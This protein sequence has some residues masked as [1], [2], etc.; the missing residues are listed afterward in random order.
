MDNP[1]TQVC[2]FGHIRHR[3]NTKK[4]K[5]QKTKKNKK[6]KNKQKTNEKKQT[7]NAQHRKLK[8]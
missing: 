8:P 3:T 6:T 2:N 7:H 4:A 1:D 5:K